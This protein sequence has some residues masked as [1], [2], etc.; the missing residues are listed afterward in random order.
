MQLGMFMMPNHPPHRAYA[1]AHAHDLDT[2][3]FAD[4]LGLSEA[5]VGE[6][7]TCKRE[8]LPCPDILIAQAFLKTSRI[9]LGAGAFLLPYHVPAELAHRVCWLDHISG[10]RFMVGIGAGGLPTD[11]DLFGVDGAAGENRDMMVEAFDLMVKFWT[12]EGPFE[13]TGTYYKGGRPRGMA[14]LGL[15]Y[16]M[17][18]LTKPYPRVAIAGLSAS[19][20]T[21]RFAGLRGF[22]PMSLAWSPNYLRSHWE[23]YVE[24][25]EASG[26]PVDRN[27]W[28]VGCEVYIAETDAEARKLAID[29]ALGESWR[30]YMLPLLKELDFLGACKHD[31]SVSDSDVTVE[32]LADNV[33][34]IGSPN[35]VAEKLGA[36]RHKVGAFGCLL[37]VIYDHTDE[38]TAYRESVTALKNEVLPKLEATKAD[39]AE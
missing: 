3:V 13:H 22:I 2:L 17:T 16:H 12:S 31:P 26:K 10:G 30:A 25:A 21:L 6:H 5:W 39:A 4:G 1:E 11:C 38:M 19:S 15:A 34:M 32:Y 36:L 28:R 20:P 33:W 9:K 8:P 18:P 24:G 37:Q 14:K 35:T 7:F 29:G 23:A 27:D